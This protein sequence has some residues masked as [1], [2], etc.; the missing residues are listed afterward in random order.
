MLLHEGPGNSVINEFLI[1]CTLNN[2][3]TLT[4]DNTPVSNPNQLRGLHT[5][6]VTPA[7]LQ[8]QF[9]GLPS[10]MLPGQTAHGTLTCSNA[11]PGPNLYGVDCNPTAVGGTV[12]NVACTPTV[13]TPV[14][15][16]TPLQNGQS[17]VCTFDLTA[18]NTQTMNIDLTGKATADGLDATATANAGM[19]AR[20]RFFTPSA[21]AVPTLGEWALMLLALGML[22]MASYGY[23]RR[24]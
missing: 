14:V 22:G 10:T 18:P 19:T 15:P 13:P 24:A 3:S 1:P 11:G 5:L 7:T 9:S 21:A 12:S 8:A 2:V 4:L 16:G 17:I 20:L 23:K 6:T